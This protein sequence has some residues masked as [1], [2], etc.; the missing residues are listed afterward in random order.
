MAI[1]TR[2]VVEHKGVE[3]LVTIDK[4]EADRYDKML[5][6]ADNLAAFI[7]AKGMSIE[8]GLLEE[9]SILLSKNKDK[10]AKMFKGIDAQSLLEEEKA[11]VV[12]LE[13]KQA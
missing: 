3:K 11:E 10:V 9:L 6:V 4:K 1:I 7:Q 12:Q 2:Y 5:D 13:T 8:D